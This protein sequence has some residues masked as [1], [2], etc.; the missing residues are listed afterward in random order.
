MQ[1]V[2]V[3]FRPQVRPTSDSEPARWL[4]LALAL[5][6]ALVL[7]FLGNAPRS[8]APAGEGPVP[9]EQQPQVLTA[10]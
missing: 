5:G 8:V 4:A 2:L 10:P 9:A 3:F 1:R 6:L 7:L